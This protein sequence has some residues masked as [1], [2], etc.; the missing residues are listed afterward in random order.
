PPE[1][2]DIPLNILYEDDDLLAINKQRGLVVHPAAGN[3]SGTLV[4]ALLH[5]CRQL[6]HLG[7]EI[8]PGIVH[9]LDKDTTGLPVVAKT[10]R[11]YLSLRQQIK[12]RTVKRAYLALV[13]GDVVQERGWVEAPIGR[14][15]VHRQKMAVVQRGGKPAFTHF[16]VVE[17]FGDYTLVECR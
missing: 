12:A 16:R 1:P 11:A 13:H 15:P 9:P 14:H 17:R 10:D 2:E 5:H 4:N 8:R 6:P 3:P 7:D